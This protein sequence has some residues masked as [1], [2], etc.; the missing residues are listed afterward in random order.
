[1]LFSNVKLKQV[2]PLKSGPDISVVP[3]HPE[4]VINQGR[5]LAGGKGVGG[6]L[7]GLQGDRLQSQAALGAGLGRETGICT[8]QCVTLGERG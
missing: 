6:K 5:P 3:V 8:F 7:K 1:M 2:A 4:L